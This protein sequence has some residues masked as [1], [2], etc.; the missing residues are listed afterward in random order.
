MVLKDLIRS[1]SL[2]LSQELQPDVDRSFEQARKQKHE[3]CTS[4]FS[5]ANLSFRFSTPPGLLGDAVSLTEG[6]VSAAVLG[7]GAVS[8][9]TG[10]VFI[11]SFRLRS[12][13]M[14]S[15][16]RSGDT[17]PSW[18]IR[19]FCSAIW[20]SKVRCLAANAALALLDNGAALDDGTGVEFEEAVRFEDDGSAGDL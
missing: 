17:E 4:A 19:T 1:H 16:F 5:F 3:Q 20:P 8:V 7:C 2:R 12:L 6:F 11:S 18:A 9:S 10:W 13:F 14:I 15:F